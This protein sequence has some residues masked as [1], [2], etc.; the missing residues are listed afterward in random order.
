MF[1]YLIQDEAIRFVSTQSGSVKVKDIIIADETGKLRITMWRN[2][3]NA[4][5]HTGNDILVKDALI[6]LSEY[7]KS[8]ILSV[9]YADRIEVNSHF[10][11]I[12][13]ENYNTKL[14]DRQIYIIKESFNMII[15][16]TQ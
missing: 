14:Q 12:Q 2:A 1:L 9:N 16:T 11:T 8:I 15:K 3:T 10:L 5:I 13:E 7:H 6:L 4:P